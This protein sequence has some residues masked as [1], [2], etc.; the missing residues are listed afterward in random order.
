[1]KS[2][3]ERLEDGTVKLTIPLAQIGIQKAR[4]EVMKEAI[5]SAEFPG[6]RKGKAPQAMVEKSLDQMKVKDEVL[7]KILPKGYIDAVN[8]HTIKP[9][10]NP[11][12]QVVSIEVFA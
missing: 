11:K 3:L 6:F 7:K 4:E 12:I 8:E 2:T 10:M 1:M 9:V 5:E